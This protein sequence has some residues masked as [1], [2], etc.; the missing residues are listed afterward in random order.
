MSLPFEDNNPYSPLHIPEFDIPFD[1]DL[2][3]DLPIDLPANPILPL[4]NLPN[5]YFDYNLNADDPIPW[6]VYKH[7]KDANFDI[8]PF[9]Q[10][11]QVVVEEAPWDPASLFNN[12]SPIF[13]P[14]LDD[15]PEW[16]LPEPPA[17]PVVEDEHRPEILQIP[18]PINDVDIL[19]Q[20][21]E[22]IAHDAV[23][24]D[25]DEV[26]EDMPE[27]VEID[28]EEID[29]N[30]DMSDSEF[31]AEYSRQKSEGVLANGPADCDADADFDFASNPLVDGNWNSSTH[32]SSLISSGFSV[33]IDENVRGQAPSRLHCVDRREEAYIQAMVRDGVL[34]EEQPTFTANHF[35]LYSKHSMRLI[36]DGRKHKR[37]CKAPPK[38]NMKSYP[39]HARL[40]AKYSWRSKFDLKNA[41][42]NLE[43]SKHI[44]HM[45]GIRTTFGNFCYTKLPFGFTWCPFI[46]HIVIDEMVKYIRSLGI[47]CTHYMDDI[48]IYAD[49]EHTCNTHMK[50][51][52]SN[53]LEAGWRLS[54]KKT[55]PA[56][57]RGTTLGLGFDL[58]QNTT[59]IP[60][61]QVEDMAAAHTKFTQASVITRRQAAAFLGTFVFWNYAYPGL[62][63]Y[64]NPL[65]R[66]VASNDPW[67]TKYNF[68][69][70]QGTIAAIISRCKSFEDCTIQHHVSEPIQYFTDAT[71]SQLG[72]IFDEAVMA[73][74]INFRQIYRAEALAVLW[75]LNQ[76]FQAL[77]VC[78]RIDNEALVNCIK[79]G[80]SKIPEANAVCKKLLEL[81]LLGYC[82]T[83]KWISTD[84][85]PADVPSRA[86]LSCSAERREYCAF[87]ADAPL[88]CV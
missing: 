31:W 61:E 24:D 12:D 71:N 14:V 6:W 69:E 8:S 13:N 77:A 65:I 72:I 84:L 56:A 34:V 73:K 55:V 19:E 76:P 88:W 62:L 36:F 58:S 80:R 15:A 59:F 64:L 27:L 66:F 30:D 10:P 17:L 63:A 68:A 86:P 54:S 29:D 42:F 40:S 2:P 43:L 50:T 39:T 46:C 16:G 53:F 11:R 75:L 7:M 57:Q 1:N 9:M 79:K 25:F 45:F 33:S 87:P 44:R 37:A 82:I 49:D 23:V 60:S 32:V 70:V 47:E 5:I 85:N 3:I 22:N 21:D 18:I 20:R 74:K 41:F 78:L 35:F 81:R 67:D 48:V 4:H 26:P 52:I 83:A 38:F 51:A 28:E